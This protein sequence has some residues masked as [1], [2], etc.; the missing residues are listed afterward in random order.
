M[1]AEYSRAKSLVWAPLSNL[2]ILFSPPPKVNLPVSRQIHAAVY[3][4]NV[5]GDVTSFIAG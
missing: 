2:P 1:R 5:A 4:Q 3:V